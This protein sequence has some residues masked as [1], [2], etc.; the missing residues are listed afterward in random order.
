MSILVEPE[1]KTAIAQLDAL[2]SMIQG[3][4]VTKDEPPIINNQE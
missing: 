3:K 4:S 1:E 2:L